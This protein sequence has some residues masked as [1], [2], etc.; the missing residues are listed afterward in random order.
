[1][2]WVEPLAEYR[3]IEEDPITGYLIEYSMDEGNYWQ[4]FKSNT[5][6]PSTYIAHIQPNKPYL[7]RVSAI[8]SSGIGPNSSSV[9]GDVLACGICDNDAQVTP[10][11]CTSINLELDIGGIREA[12]SSCPEAIA[13]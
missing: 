9:V 6:S 12:L 8:N 7:F 11:P 4:Q 2:F 10:L 13:D 5:R 1:L 3:E